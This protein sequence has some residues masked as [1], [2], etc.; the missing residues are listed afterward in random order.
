[1][2]YR[3]TAATPTTTFARIKAA[4]AVTLPSEAEARQKALDLVRYTSVSAAIVE[5]KDGWTYHVNHWTKGKHKGE[6]RA[7]VQRS[8]LLDVQ[9]L[10]P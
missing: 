5:L 4:Y 10:T 8:R 7:Y 6:L 3:T 9:H 1:M 2:N